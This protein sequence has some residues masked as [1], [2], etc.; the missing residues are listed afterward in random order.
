MVCL[1]LITLMGS[2]FA[3]SCTSD[4]NA[5]TNYWNMT[6][7]QKNG[8]YHKFESTVMDLKRDSNHSNDVADEKNGDYYKFEASL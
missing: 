5:S 4:Y 7:A 1:S 8:D 2:A 6:T 3:Q